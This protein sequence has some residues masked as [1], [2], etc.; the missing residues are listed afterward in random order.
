VCD[1]VGIGNTCVTDQTLDTDELLPFDGSIGIWPRQACGAL[2][3]VTD[4]QTMS[5]GEH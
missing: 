2:T 4:A 5:D 1:E 3:V